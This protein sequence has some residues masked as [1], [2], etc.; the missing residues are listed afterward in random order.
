MRPTRWLTVILLSCVLGLAGCHKGTDPYLRDLR[1]DPQDPNRVSI[2]RA[3]LDA[4]LADLEAC[5]A[6]KKL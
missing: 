4:L 5:Y 3:Y 2:E 1:Q 6:K